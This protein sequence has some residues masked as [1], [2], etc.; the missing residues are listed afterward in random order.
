MWRKYC[1]TL[2]IQMRQEQP[3]IVTQQLWN[4]FHSILDALA[5]NQVL[6]LRFTFL[7]LCTSNLTMYI[8]ARPVTYV[9]QVLFGLLITNSALPTTYQ[10]REQIQDLPTNVTLGFDNGTLVRLPDGIP[11]S[12]G[13][14]TS[15][16]SVPYHVPNTAVTLNFTHFGYRIPVLRALSILSKA[17]QEVLSHLA[18]SSADAPIHHNF[19]YST[20]VTSRMPHV[21]SVVVQTYGDLGLSWLQ[22]DQIIEGLTQFINGAGVDR[23]VH[24]QNLQ[25]E[26]HLAET[27]RVAIGLLWCTP[28]RGRG[29][30]LAELEERGEVHQYLDKRV[31]LRPGLANET[32]PRSTNAS[33]LIL[34]PAPRASFPIP[35]T[36][37]SLAFVWLGDPIPSEKVNKCFHGA[38]MEIAPYLQEGGSDL[39]SQ[40]EFLFSIKVGKAHIAIQIYGMI[41]TSWSQLNSIITG[42]FYFSNG[43][44]TLHEE[45]HFRNLGFDV[46][47]EDGGNIGYGNLLA[48]PVK[49]SGENVVSV[50]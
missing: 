7:Y 33:S 47:D 2:Q 6:L 42:L 5:A 23:Q 19:A 3:P 25:F 1:N 41:P 24:Y 17:R 9:V 32:S 10:L 13:T 20:P 14:S 39:I 11:W 26:I 4:F 30:G 28:G 43:I 12:P 40:N 16:D 49:G 35:G 15:K 36:S 46:K 48:P 21:C 45:E 50:V 22:L 27:G 29:R 31:L 37:N 8:V 44:G 34:S 18:S 38:F